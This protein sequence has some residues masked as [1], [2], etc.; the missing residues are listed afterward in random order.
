[1]FIYRLSVSIILVISFAS[2]VFAGNLAGLMPEQVG[3]LRR[4]EMLTGDEAQAAVDKLHGKPLPAEAS[5]V[6]RYAGPEQGGRPAEVWV[7]RV[8][9]EKE[10]RRQTGQMVHLMFENPRSPFK[11]PKRLTINE[12]P[13]YRFEGMGQAHLIWFSSDL[14]Y[15]ISVSPKYEMVMG[16]AFC[17]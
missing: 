14:V 17:R 6:A 7:S 1:M 16:Q 15:W 13:V 3:E 11:N 2:V 5:V 8:S 10:A 9:S 4:V 12:V